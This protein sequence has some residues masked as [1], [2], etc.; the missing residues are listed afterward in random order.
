M[1]VLMEAVLNILGGTMF[2][3]IFCLG[4]GKASRLLWDVT[5]PKSLER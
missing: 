3:A 1:K 2:L 5:T 4:A